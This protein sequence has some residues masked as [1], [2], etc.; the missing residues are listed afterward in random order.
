MRKR[1]RYPYF[2]PML[3]YVAERLVRRATGRRYLAEISSNV[4]QAEAAVQSSDSR[5][6]SADSQLV[7]PDYI[8]TA[9]DSSTESLLVVVDDIPEKTKSEEKREEQRSDEAM[10]DDKCA[11]VRVCRS[12]ERIDNIVVC[13]VR[14]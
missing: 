9:I 6:S 1:Y 7:D 14:I 4:P 13:S 11:Q 2:I 12:V 8:P 5:T 10:S 3:W